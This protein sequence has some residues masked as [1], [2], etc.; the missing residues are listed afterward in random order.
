MGF[1]HNNRN[2]EKPTSSWYLWETYVF[3]KGNGSI[4]VTFHISLFCYFHTTYA[5]FYSRCLIVWLSEHPV[6]SNS[7][8][9][10]LHNFM[11]WTLTLPLQRLW[12][13]QTQMGTLVMNWPQ[14]KNLRPLHFTTFS[15][16][17]SVQYRWFCQVLMDLTKCGLQL[18]QV[19][20]EVAS[21][22]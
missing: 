5:A 22:V 14:K 20:Y 4:P 19:L 17:K 12:L 1:H 13:C 15:F 9:F 3:L 8:H 18:L 11:Y 21:Q 10:H 2:P 7:S 16:P 6:V